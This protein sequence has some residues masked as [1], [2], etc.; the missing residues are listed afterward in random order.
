MFL[1]FLLSNVAVAEHGESDAEDGE[2]TEDVSLAAEV[3]SVG[4]CGTDSGFLPSD[5]GLEPART[6]SENAF[7]LLGIS[8][9]S[10]HLL[11]QRMPAR[12]SSPSMFCV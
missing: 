5:A 6:S 10:S 2:A 4:T 1:V 8:H 12:D 3:S 11:L 7:P 9:P